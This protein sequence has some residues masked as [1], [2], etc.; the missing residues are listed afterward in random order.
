MTQPSPTSLYQ[1]D[2]PRH[3]IAPFNLQSDRIQRLL[4]INFE[5]DPDREYIGF[6]PQLFDNANKG[7]G[8]LVIGWRR[9]G[10][11]DVYHQPSLRLTHADYAM[12]AK[13]AADLIPCDFGPN[14]FEITARGIDLDLRFSD[15][16]GRA[17]VLRIVERHPR[18]RQPFGLLAPFP[19]S[20]EKPPN[21]PLPLLYDF[22]FVR[23]AH[24]EIDVSI[25]GRQH[26]LDRLPA[27][28]DWSWVYFVR[29]AAD[30][31]ILNWNT[32]YEGPLTPHFVTGKGSLEADGLIYELVENAGRHEIVAMRPSEAHHDVRFTF[33]PPFPDLAALREG[34]ARRGRFRI[35]MEAALGDVSDDYV[36][37][38]HGA[39]VQ[40][41][42]H[43]SG[44]WRPGVRRWS[45]RIIFLLVSLFRK[46]PQW[47]RWQ[48]TLDLSQPDAPHLQA[49]WEKF[50]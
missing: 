38:R 48:A 31:L 7:Q 49:R 28:I 33:D 29:Y 50:K 16:F 41:R 20:T 2:A 5:R 9:D 26:A 11:L 22:Y 46:W 27:P 6:E 15:K 4:L 12:V 35:D 8:L 30:P 32:N 18:P 1:P 13:G 17:V 24:T 14:H 47:Y 42:L 3:F 40:M 39:Q 19:S 10:R 36:V 43:P 21:L 34:A 25:D 23:R 44:G 37:E 45:I